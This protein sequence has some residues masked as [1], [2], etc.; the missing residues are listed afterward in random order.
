M[1]L[2][3]LGVGWSYGHT[4]DYSDESMLMIISSSSLG[5]LVLVPDNV[6]LMSLLEQVDYVLLSLRGSISIE[7]LYSWGT[8]IKVEGQHCFSSVG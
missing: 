7:G 1:E 5:T 8:V 2:T 6:R 3:R 4:L